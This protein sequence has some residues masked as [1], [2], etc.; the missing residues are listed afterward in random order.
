MIKGFDDV[1]CCSCQWFWGLKCQLYACCIVHHKVEAWR[2]G[3]F[4]SSVG[5]T[6]LRKCSR[7]SRD[8]NVVYILYASG[9]T[10][11]GLYSFTVCACGTFSSE[12]TAPWRSCLGHCP[13]FSAC[14]KIWISCWW[15]SSGK[16]M[17][18][19]L[20]TASKPVADLN[21][22]A[23]IAFFQQDRVIGVSVMTG[24]C[25]ND[26]VMARTSSQCEGSKWR[27][28]S[29]RL[30]H[31]WMNDSCISL[32]FPCK[33]ISASTS[34]TVRVWGL[35][36]HTW[37]SSICITCMGAWAGFKH[38]CMLDRVSVVNY[39]RSFIYNF[40]DMGN[41]LSDKH[42]DRHWHRF[43]YIFENSV[44]I[45]SAVGFCDGYTLGN[46]TRLKGGKMLA[47]H[48]WYMLR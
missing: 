36:N 18:S 38:G 3:I 41:R 30:T 15:S 47:K 35:V 37:P 10:V 48:L 14:V 26:C 27:C 32:G 17:R 4:P 1:R 46:Y 31:S 33:V 8:L 19:C 44:N 25:N 23:W 9:I 2:P 39:H 40:N 22:F 29:Q 42:A 21:F 11:I 43:T 12:N 34:P 45:W 7:T 20:A 6:C 28:R 5:G 24:Q 13:V 16:D